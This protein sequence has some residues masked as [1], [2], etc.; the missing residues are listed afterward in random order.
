ML[1][2]CR[3]GAG[4]AGG[5]VGLV[6]EGGGSPTSA[7]SCTH[8]QS[9][10]PAANDVSFGSSNTYVRVMVGGMAFHYVP[11]KV[12]GITGDELAVMFLDGRFGC[13][14][15]PY[16]SNTEFSAEEIQALRIGAV[17]RSAYDN[18]Q[19]QPQPPPTPL[20]TNPQPTLS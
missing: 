4:W 1:G 13:I 14:K 5:M 20:H 9:S 16:V 11:A 7:S 19:A 17:R 3:V 2:G 12:T 6:E 18:E 15:F 10:K 8:P